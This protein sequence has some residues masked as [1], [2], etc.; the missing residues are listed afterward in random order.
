[1]IMKVVRK[2]VSVLDQRFQETEK[3]FLEAMSG[4]KKVRDAVVSLIQ[5]VTAEQ[6]NK[7]E[8]ILEVTRWSSDLSPG[9]TCLFGLAGSSE[10]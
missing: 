6:R 1:M 5:R 8:V 4:T 9:L 10:I 2:M 3:R 7:T